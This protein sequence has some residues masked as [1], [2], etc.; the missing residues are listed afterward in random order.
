MKI[1]LTGAT[2]FL[3]KYLLKELLLNSKIKVAIL[4]RNPDKLGSLNIKK[5]N[6]SY[7]Y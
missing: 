3:G 5:K 4:I 6:N 1:L 2:G 7:K